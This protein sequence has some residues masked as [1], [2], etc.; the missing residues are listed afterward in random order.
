MYLRCVT[1]KLL[2]T[3]A[4]KIH[5]LRGEAN[6]RYFAISDGEQTKDKRATE[7]PNGNKENNNL[8]NMVEKKR[9]QNANYIM[10]VIK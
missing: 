4:V 7:Q 9:N 5:L 2:K 8:D 1:L 3:T 6:R 10:S